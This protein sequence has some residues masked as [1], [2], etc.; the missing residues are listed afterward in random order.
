MRVAAAGFLDPIREPWRRARQYALGDEG[1]ELTSPKNRRALAQVF[2]RYVAE[3]RDP[4]CRAYAVN[5]IAVHEHVGSL[6]RLADRLSDLRKP[7][8]PHSILLARDVIAGTG[9]Y[10]T[11]PAPTSSGRRLN[12]HWTHWQRT[13]RATH[14][15]SGD[16]DRATE[17][18]SARPAPSCLPEP[19]EGQAAA[20][21]QASRST[22]RSGAAF[23][24]AWLTAIMARRSLILGAEQRSRSLHERGVMKIDL[25]RTLAFCSAQ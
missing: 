12:L 11:A 4:R 13:R 5:R 9:R 22:H 18:T 15:E 10:S 14:L 24:P 19:T 7:V 3:I 2:R 17:Q 21:W 16:R 8:S 6:A 20:R 1:L 25:G 23:R